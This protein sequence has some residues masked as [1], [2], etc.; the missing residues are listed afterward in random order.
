LADLVIELL[1]ERDPIWI[2]FPEWLKN[3]SNTTYRALFMK[4]DNKF[5]NSVEFVNEE[6]KRRRDVV[7]L[8]ENDSCEIYVS[9]ES[10]EGSV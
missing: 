5:R 9:Q 6:I 4:L 10:Q 8:Q 2:G 7:V 1:T 3:T